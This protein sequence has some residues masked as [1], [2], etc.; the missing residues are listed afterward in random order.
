M[1]EIPLLRTFS[2]TRLVPARHANHQLAVVVDPLRHASGVF[3]WG[4]DEVVPLYEE[5]I[6][7]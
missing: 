4:E 6:S 5:P 1:V 3:A 2:R 7:I